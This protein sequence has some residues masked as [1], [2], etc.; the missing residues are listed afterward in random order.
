MKAGGL[1]RRVLLQ[2]GS[3]ALMLG[4]H[5]IARGATILA[6]RVWPAADYTRVTI[7]SDARLT[8]Q[9]L[10]VGS[11]P[12]LAVDIEGIELNSELR[13]LVGK[14]KPGDPYIN[15][16]RVGQNAPT[17]VRIVFD[18]KQTVRPQVFSL[19]PVAAYKH[20]LVLDLYP[21][22]AIDPMEALIAERLRDSPSPGTG[23]N[24]NGSA[25]AGIAPSPSPVPGAAPAP[26][27]PAMPAVDPLGDLMAQQSMRPGPAAPAP[28]VLVAPSPLPPV[29]GTAPV[30]PVSPPVAVAR[31]GATA[32]RTDRIIIVALDPGHGGEDPGATGPS[33]TR[34][35]DIVLQVAFRLRDRIN[36]GSVNGNP[37]RAFLTRDADFFVP[38]GVRVQKARRV[39]ADLFVSIHADAFTTP[40]ARGASVFALSQSGA[41]SS[42]ARWLA[43]KENDADKVGGV[44][45]GNHEAQVQRALLDMSTTAQINDSMKLGGAMLGEIKGIGAR[46]H[47]GQVEQAGF[48]VLKAPDIP[49]V[50]VETAFISNPEEEANLRRVDYQES[51]ADALMRGIQRY[52]AQN[53]PLARSRQ[54]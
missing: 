34:E 26:V 11:P 42:A 18:L 22:Q 46:L 14:I 48:A 39:Q 3:I 30:R 21:E 51:L 49:S 43:N 20:R 10:V 50:L 28:P 44:N 45:V 47:K 27:R 23:I 31:G 2:G 15:G 41:S 40:A 6:V 29:V 35:K 13:E 32:S 16:L 7:E 19:A 54:L 8:S 36:A 33:G 9:Q 25:V 12:R 1:K 52:F 38:L 5:Q 53:P 37:M 24:N 17:V 4:V